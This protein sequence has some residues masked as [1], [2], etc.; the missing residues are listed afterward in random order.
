MRASPSTTTIALPL[1]GL[2]LAS[3]LAAYGLALV[4]RERDEDVRVGHRRDSLEC[5]PVIATTLTTPEIGEAVRESARICKEA[6]E[7][8]RVPGKAGNERRSV[9][10]ARGTSAEGAWELLRMRERLL[11]S[12]D[13][14]GQRIAAALIGGLGAPSP[15]LDEKP[16]RGATALDGVLGNHTSD[17]VRGVLRKMR[18][19]AESIRDEELAQFWFEPDPPAATDEDKTGWAPRGALIDPVHQWLAALG[20]G[21]LPV[22]LVARGHAQTPCVWSRG[23]DRGV[24]VP[25]L[26][27]PVSPARVRA[28]LQRRELCA[29]ELD[30]A[31]G[32]A[33]RALGVSETVEFSVIDRTTPQSVAFSFGRGVLREL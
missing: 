18:P 28:L 26:A 31:S 22:G 12:A 7:A 3:H 33:L 9:I 15:W 19:A 32:A 6:I 29:P 2:V 23:R 21:M 24:R 20:L 4:L 10:W 17:F 13:G 14:G 11:D 25:V 30:I 8:D 27:R 1:S 16:H 5:E